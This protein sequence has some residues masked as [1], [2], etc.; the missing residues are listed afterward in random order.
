MRFIKIV[1]QFKI[2]FA[3]MAATATSI[4]VSAQ[5]APAPVGPV[6][7]ARQIEWYHR[8]M[9]AFFHFGMNTFTNDNEGDGKADP[10]MFNPTALNCKQWM[11]VLKRAGIPCAILVAKHAD[12]FCNWPSA[13]TDYSVKNSGWKGGRGDVVK[14]FTDACKTSGI[15]AAI[16]LGPHDRHDSRY[17]TPAYGDYYANQLSE[18]LRNYGPIWEIWWDGAGADKL[19]TDLYTRWADT[20]RRLQPQCVVF[21]TKNSYPFADCRWVGNESGYAGD[22]CWSTIN[23]TSIR[24]EAVHIKELNEGELNGA[25][26]VPA[27]VD[28]SVRPSWFYHPEEDTKVKSLA[29]LWEIYLK[30]VGRNSVLLLN[31]SPNKEGIIPAIDAQRT[32]SLR[33]LINNTFKTNLVKG[34]A[35]QTLHGRGQKFKAANLTDNLE[36]TYYASADAFTTD[37]ISFHLT[38]AKTFDV[39]MLQEVIQLGHRTTGWSVDYSTDG[40]NWAAIPEATGKQS[41]GYKWIVTFKPVTATHVRL[42][43][44]S[45]KA[46]AA[47]HTFGIYKQAG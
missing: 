12:G 19:T 36:S 11:S 5:P 15:K 39:L 40:K 10:K 35:I 34:A 7:N 8:E 44:T 16:Y 17:G 6:P 28:V 30:S 45:G 2:A 47:I 38:S 37:T 43:I 25:A 33:W 9:I 18:L 26:Y 41:I 24:D 3:V 23:P 31:Y 20:V 32:D 13:H 42:R 4:T 46:S 27:E 29:T 14:E 21:G 1:L 22:P